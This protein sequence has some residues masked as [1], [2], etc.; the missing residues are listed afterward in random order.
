MIISIA[1]DHGGFS[2]KQHLV[3][4]L[5]RHGH[6]LLDRGCSSEDSVDYPD[7]ALLVVRDILAGHADFGVLVCGTGIGMSIAA[8]RHA[9]IRAALVHRDEYA[10]LAR[11]HNDA[12][13]ICLGGRFFSPTE[14]ERMVT[15]FLSTPFGGGRHERRIK[16]LDAC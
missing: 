6:E 2:L 10:K 9:G 8:N 7:Y 3:A 14:A 13:I 11:E 5:E 16:K 15:T 1:A 12:N 4:F